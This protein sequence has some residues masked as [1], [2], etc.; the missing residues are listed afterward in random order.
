MIGGMTTTIPKSASVEPL[1]NRE[2]S[3]V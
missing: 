3:A 1:I 2:L